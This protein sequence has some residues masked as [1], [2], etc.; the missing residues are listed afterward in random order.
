MRNF[1]TTRTERGFVRINFD[2]LYQARCSLQ[3]SS[4]ATDYAIWLGVDR[5]PADFAAAG[6][7]VIGYRMHLTQS[8]VR[9][10]LPLLTI[11]ATTGVLPDPDQA[12]K[13]IKEAIDAETKSDG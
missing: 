9:A 12:A 13:L 1:T 11:F 5:T 8:D 10:L 4:L 3:E 6:S 7:Q 2:D